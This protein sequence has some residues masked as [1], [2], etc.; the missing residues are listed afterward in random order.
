MPLF[1]NWFLKN[2]ILCVSTKNPIRRKKQ[3]PWLNPAEGVCFHHIVLTVGRGQSEI[4]PL[5]RV[6]PCKESWGE[7][8]SWFILCLVYLH[9]VGTMTMGLLPFLLRRMTAFMAMS[10]SPP[11]SFS[12]SDVLFLMASEQEDKI[13]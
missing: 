6:T 9:T 4:L 3:S 8:T 11:E 2:F 7:G 5:E 10:T 13:K 12:S 1:L